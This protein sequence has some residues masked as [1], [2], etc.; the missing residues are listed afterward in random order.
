M[1]KHSEGECL[2]LASWKQF[3]HDFLRGE[4]KICKGEGKVGYERDKAEQRCGP[5]S[6]VCVVQFC[7]PVK[8]FQLL[9]GW[10]NH[11]SRELNIPTKM[12]P[13]T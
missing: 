8:Q 13:I 10:G 9:I 2:R 7:I 3:L 4:K 1:I 11:P 5:W 12:A 6:V